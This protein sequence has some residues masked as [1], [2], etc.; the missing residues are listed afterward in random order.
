MNLI[1]TCARNL[2]SDAKDEIKRILNSLG[3]EGAHITIT[4]MSGILT[5][6][7]KLEPPLII[8]HVKK[9]ISEEPW[10]V[11]YCMRIIPVYETVTTDL[12]EIASAVSKLTNII[13]KQDT[14]KILVEKRNYDLPKKEII[15]E[16]AKKIDNKVSLDNP[17][18]VVLVEII[19]KTT[20][21]SVIKQDLI[22]SI[23]KMK[24]RLE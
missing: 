18:W 11:R 12:V 8:Q 10:L 16:I 21:V 6:D 14:Y 4:D 22:L 1:I 2:E 23:P 3:D 13:Q 17:D 5:I 15:S 24:R 20:G 7:T 19:G 9:T